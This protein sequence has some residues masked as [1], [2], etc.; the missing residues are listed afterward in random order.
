MTLKPSAIRISL[1]L[2]T[3]FSVVPA[4]SADLLQVRR[5][6]LTIVLNSGTEPAELPAVAGDVVIASGP[7]SGRPGT[8]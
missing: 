8:R 2:G 4:L 3:L 6:P 5:G 7:M 1:L